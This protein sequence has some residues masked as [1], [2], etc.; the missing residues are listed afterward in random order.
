MFFEALQG[1][2]TVPPV[3]GILSPANGA[4]DVPADTPIEVDVW[5]FG[6]GIDLASTFLLV[7]GSRRRSSPP[8]TASAPMLEL[9]VR[10]RPSGIVTVGLRS[11]DLATTP[12]T[13]DREIARFSIAGASDLQGDLNRDGRVDGTDLVRFALR[14]GA[15]RGDIASAPTP[16]S[17]RRPHDGIDL[18]VL[19]RFRTVVL[20]KP[21]D[22]PAPLSRRE[23][24]RALILAYMQ[25][26]AC[27]LPLPPGEEGRGGEGS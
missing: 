22:S 14:F 10:R 3:H 26:L 12:N 15:Q 19:R 5:D 21:F 24:H 11:R 2:D 23:R 27:F 6:T 8:A 16:T 13:V 20:E 17:T 25:R 7:N 1:I 9:H 18:A 4:N